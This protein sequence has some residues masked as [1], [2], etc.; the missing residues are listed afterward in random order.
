MKKSKL[1]KRV[2]ELETRIAFQEDT[3]N[4]LD[5]VLVHQQR[6]IDR[7]TRRVE[8]LVEQVQQLIPGNEEDDEPPPHY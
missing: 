1:E 3:L 6:G 4:K 7:V 8:M 5:E 2:V